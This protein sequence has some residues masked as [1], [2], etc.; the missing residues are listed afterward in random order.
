[1]KIIRLNIIIANIMELSMCARQ[2]SK[3][4]ACVCMFNTNNSLLSEV[5]KWRD[6]QEQCYTGLGEPEANFIRNFVSWLISS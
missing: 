4:F 3:Y 6:M 5:N 2:C 1:M